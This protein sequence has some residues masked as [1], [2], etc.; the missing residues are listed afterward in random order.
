MLNERCSRAG[1]C[2]ASREEATQRAQRA[3]KDPYLKPMLFFSSCS[4]RTATAARLEGLEQGPGL[5]ARADPAAC[6][7]ET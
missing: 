2:L 7:D 1:R 4:A 5:G 6:L 3:Q